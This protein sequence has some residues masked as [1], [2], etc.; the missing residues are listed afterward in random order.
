M[1]KPTPRTVDEV[2]PGGYLLYDNTWPNDEAF[3]RDDI[4]LLGVPLARMCNEVFD[5]SRTR[6]LMKNVAYVGALAAL[7][8]I[9]LEVIRE[10]LRQTSTPVKNS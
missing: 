6:V 2:S 8:D 9:D 4:T 5:D 7:L 10:L 3:E 1:L